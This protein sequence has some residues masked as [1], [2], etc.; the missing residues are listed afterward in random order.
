MSQILHEHAYAKRFVI[1]LKFKLRILHFYLLNL[2]NLLQ[3]LILYLCLS[4]GLFARY[5]KTLFTLL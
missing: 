2:E 3:P 1:Y 4:G 5:F